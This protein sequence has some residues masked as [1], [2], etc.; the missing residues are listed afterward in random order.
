MKVDRDNIEQ[1]WNFCDNYNICEKNVFGKK[2]FGRICPGA[3]GNCRWKLSIIIF[4]KILG[5]SIWPM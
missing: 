2:N 4:L 5:H 3:W 1:G